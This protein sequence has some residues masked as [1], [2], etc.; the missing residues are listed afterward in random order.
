MEREEL[1]RAGDL[2]VVEVL[3]HFARSQPQGVVHE[4]AGVTMFA[5]SPL[6]PGPFDNGM[7]VVEARTTP[8]DALTRAREFFGALGRTFC[9]WTGDHL[10]PELERAVRD[11]GFLS[12]GDGTP[13]MVLRDRLADAIAPEGVTLRAVDD[14]RT[15]RDYIAVLQQSFTPSQGT[16][17]EVLE[18]AFPDVDSLHGPH[19]R[20]VV[21]YAGEA[22][23]AGA[24]VLVS[25]G[26]A[27]VQYVGTVEG[28]RGRGFGELVTRWVGNVGFD[29][30]G[31][32]AALQASEMGEP[33]YRRM[34]YE[35]VTSYRYY[36]A[37]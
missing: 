5:G 9:V 23:V 34:G 20:A 10:D 30:G 36:M 15:R 35:T 37:T 32:I 18:N 22:P 24:F 8:A 12:L 4:E 1:L 6:W 19:L 14:D 29:L 13:Q 16:P 27:G 7:F 25:H 17:A 31:R 26:I 2:N 3:R 33:V 21:A 28:A 11:A